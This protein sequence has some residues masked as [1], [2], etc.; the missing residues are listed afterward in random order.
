MYSLNLGEFQLSSATSLEVS[1]AFL[2]QEPRKHIDDTLVVFISISYNTRL[3]SLSLS[4]VEG[5]V[6]C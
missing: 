3:Y 5:I 6:T 1:G 2:M 4:E